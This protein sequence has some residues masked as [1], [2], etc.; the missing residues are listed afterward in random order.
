M[1]RVALVCLLLCLLTA[2]AC[3]PVFFAPVSDSASHTLVVGAEPTVDIE[4]AAGDVTVEP[5]PNA[6]VDLAY[7][8]HANGQAALNALRLDVTQ[9]GDRVNVRFQR[10][11]DLTANQSVTLR[12]RAPAS[13]RISVTTGSGNI[14]VRGTQTGVTARTGAGAIDVRDAAGPLDLRTGSGSIEVW[15]AAGPVRLDSS[16]GAIKAEG[17]LTGESRISVA[18]GSVT[19][20]LYPDA[21]LKVT[22]AG[23]AIADDFGLSQGGGR[24]VAGAIGDGSKGSLDISAAAGKVALIRR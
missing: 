5:G 18:A 22:A 14:V 12:V 24:S 23:L 21:A 10:S 7:T 2:P 3:A 15:G 8:R 16:A 17:R 11:T 13:A 9:S 6:T 19:V 20:R 1:S 4:L